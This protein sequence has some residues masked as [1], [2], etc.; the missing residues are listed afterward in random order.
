MQEPYYFSS[1]RCPVRAQSYYLIS[2]MISMTDKE[3]LEMHLF[4]RFVKLCKD[5]PRGVSLK[6][7][8]PDFLI[9]GGREVV[10]VE[11]SK[12]L[13]EEERGQEYSASER[14]SIEQELAINA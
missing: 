7:A 8:S 14:N 5:L 9:K 2:R 10:G 13:N 3:L 11:I 6:T 1:A 4:D 12:I